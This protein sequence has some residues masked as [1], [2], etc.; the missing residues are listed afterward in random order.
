[1]TAHTYGPH[2]RTWRNLKILADELAATSIRA[3][4]EADPGRFDA[5]S[6]RS[7]GILLDLSRQQV[8]VGVLEELIELAKQTQLSLEVDRMF[9]GEAVNATEGRA[10]L[11]IA[12]R[13][14]AGQAP[15]SCRSSTPSG[16][17]STNLPMRCTLGG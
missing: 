10:A 4:F 2:T 11:H 8:D 13:R 5:L 15:T 9:T 7:L 14:P 3:L 6:V 1:M 16:P 17:R 12:L